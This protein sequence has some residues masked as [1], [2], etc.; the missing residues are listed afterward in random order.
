MKFSLVLSFL[1]S[2]F[3]AQEQ[4]SRT[5]QIDSLKKKA[6]SFLATSTID[7]AIYYYEQA[8]GIALQKEDWDRHIGASI[9]LLRIYTRFRN[10]GKADTLINNLQE[11]VT[12]HRTSISSLSLAKFYYGNCTYLNAHRKYLEAL[13]YLNKAIPLLR[14]DDQQERNLITRLLINKGLIYEVFSDYKT[15][16]EFYERAINI[17][18]DAED[19]ENRFLPYLYYNL[20][21]SFHLVN[22][23]ERSLEYLNKTRFTYEKRGLKDLD[24]LIGIYDLSG[25]NLTK[26]DRFDEAKV[27][28]DKAIDTSIKLFGVDGYATVKSYLNMAVNLIDDKQYEQAV[29]FLNKHLPYF[30]EHKYLLARAYGNIGLAYRGIGKDQEVVKT[31]GKMIEV[32]EAYDYRRDFLPYKMIGD[33]YFSKNDLN[34]AIDYYQ[35]E[36]IRISEG[37]TDLNVFKN[38][39]IDQITQQDK[40]SMFGL[41]KNKTEVLKKMAALD[42]Q[43]LPGIRKSLLSTCELGIQLIKELR[44]Q[45]ISNPIKLRLAEA[46]KFFF[47]EV[48]N[49]YLG[50]SARSKSDSSVESMFHYSETYREGLL[51]LRNAEASARKYLNLPG[52]VIEEEKQLKSA[53]RYY[54]SSL[55]NVKSTEDSLENASRLFDARRSLEGLVKDLEKSY[56]KYYRLKYGSQVLPVKEVQNQLLRK[57]QAL[58]EYFM[59]DHSVYILTITR[60]QVDAR[61][62]NIDSTSF[63]QNIREAIEIAKEPGTNADVEKGLAAFEHTYGKLYH[64]L[65]EPV[66]EMIKDKDLVIIPDGLLTLLPFELLV[67]SYGRQPINS[68]RDL[69]YLLKQHAISYGSSATALFQK[70]STKNTQNL[71]GEV[72]AFAPAFNK[73]EVVLSEAAAGASRANLVPLDWAE[74]EVKGISQH[75]ETDLLL[76]EDAL[77]SALKEKGK[78]YK[79]IHIASHGLID[80]KTPDYSRIA[81]HL[82][83]ED[84]VDDGYLHAFEIYNIELNA[85]MVV[86]SACNT[87]YGK[88]IG[89][90]GAINLA[91]SFFYA[92]VKSIVMSLWAANDRSTFHVMDEFYSQ[93]SKGNEKD[94][95]LSAAKLK[96]LEDCSERKAHPYYWASF[97]V[98]GDTRSLSTEK[99]APPYIIILF[100]AF[101]LF[102]LFY[103]S[104][105]VRR[106][107]KSLN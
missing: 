89:G 97:V 84:S 96:Y 65:I 87:G 27:Y 8:S 26:L 76:S 1:L 50:E 2:S 64:L 72:L 36:L 54:Q 83:Q 4:Q 93:L 60:T 78:N 13:E 7:S 5:G 3:L 81:F 35:Q 67:A 75:F 69:P 86:L 66:S 91:R 57:D 88:V 39:S 80:D 94:K 82:N 61:K 90:E 40:L 68:Y 46:N 95:A 74:A 11:I 79:I 73:K 77:E 22:D 31:F 9:P 48:M 20:S 102:L 37:F 34:K 29:S 21:V 70:F 25:L 71:P 6:D 41:L 62:I 28:H 52:E 53:A 107:R 10:Y 55:K 101:I 14:Y 45:P 105:R 103:V 17:I 98:N 18:M 92:G 42:S 19:H 24:L 12:E 15:S 56:P 49:E 104:F 23:Y 51:A 44:R 43:S 99:H 47:S 100:S 33:F 106:M 58:L 59:G 38:P 63:A 30:Y 85:D 16:V 32:I